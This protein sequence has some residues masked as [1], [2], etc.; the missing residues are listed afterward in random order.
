M[1]GKAS[2]GKDPD[3]NLPPPVVHTMHS[4]WVAANSSVTLESAG[5]LNYYYTYPKGKSDFIKTDIFKKITYKDIYPGIDLEYTFP[6]GKQGI[7]YAIILH[8]GADISKVKLE[9]SNAGGLKID[10]EGNV[11]FNSKVGEITDHAPVS[12]YS[13]GS[14][15]IDVSYKVSGNTE[16]F[17]INENYDKSK[18]LVI[19]PWSTDPLYSSIYDRAYDID[20]DY[21][22][23][24]YAFGSWMPL[25]LEKFSSTGSPLWVFNATAFDTY[26]YY[27]DVAV[28]RN[29]GTAYITEGFNSSGARAMKINTLGA[30]LGTSPGT[31]QLNEF[32]RAVF[33]PCYGNIIIGAGG[34]SGDNQACILDTNMISVTPVNILSATTPFHDI[35]LIAPDPS[36]LVCYMAT[37]QSASHPTVFNNVIVSLPLPSL[38]PT[39]YITPDNFGFQE[40]NV[41]SYVASG[42]D[43]ANGYDGIAVSPNWLYITNSLTL[44]RLYKNTG[45]LDDSIAVSSV[46]LSQNKPDW[47]GLAVSPCDDIF[48]G[49]QDTVRVY[50]SSMQVD[51][52]IKLANTI[53]DL[54]YGQNNL[55]YAAGD[56]FVCAINVPPLASLIS[57]ASG[58]PSSCSACDGRA[59]VTIN[60]GI[61]PFQFSWSNGSTNQTDTGMCAGIY[62]V[63]VT[64]GSC[65]PRFDSA[66][67]IITGKVGY[68]VT[69]RDTNPNCALSKGNITAYPTGGIPPY[70]YSW[71]NGETTQKDTGLIAGT[72]TCIVSDSEGCRTFITIT[73][74]NPVTPTI[75]VV[76]AVDS[77]CNGA[78]VP[79]TASGVKTYS[80]TPTS[81]LTCN[82]CPNP[83]A[84]PTVTTTYT[85]VGFDSNGCNAAATVTIK[86]YAVPKPVITGKDSVCSGYSDTL[87]ASGGNNYSWSTG[88][89]T[90]SIVK[91][92]SSTQTFTLTS[93]NGD[94]F[95][96]TT[97]TVHIVSPAAA[98]RPS[99]DSTC[100]GD[101]VKLTGS[102]GSTYLWSN[103]STTSVIIVSPTVPTTYTLY[104][105]YG[106]CRDSAT[107]KIGI[108]KPLTATIN[109]NVDSVCPNSPVVI[110][111]NITGGT[112]TYKWST[113]A[114]TSS[115]NVSDTVSTTYTATVYGKCDTLHLPYTVK[116]V[117]LPKPVIKGTAWKCLGKTDTLFASGGTTYL[118]SN[119]STGT[120]YIT[121]NI[122]AD[123]TITLI[124]FNSL[125]C[126]DTTTF[127]ITLRAA[128]KVTVNPPSLTCANQPV[129][130]TANA[131]G[132]GSLTYLWEPGGET[133]SS[134]TVTDSVSTTYT[135]TV[136]D[137]CTTFK[138]TTITPVSPPL[139]ACC[140]KVILQGNDT[141]IGAFGKTLASYTWAPPVTCLNP[142]WCD[143]VKVTPTVTTTYTVTGTDS[144][145]CQVERLVTIIV[146]VPC[147][148]FFVPNV[149]TP[150]N[151]G[152]LG[153]DN[154]FYIKTENMSAWSII[155]YDRW[156]KEMFNSTN[157]NSYWTGTTEGGGNAPDG[158]YY[159]IVTGTCQG[160]TYK[161]DGFL[162][163]IR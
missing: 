23:N 159:Y 148:N 14:G 87:V 138:T 50:N 134:I 127:T 86:V 126:A 99:K 17:S 101:T 19:D 9:Y 83:T 156:G 97:F 40:S 135:L 18:T 39:N 62:T 31:T 53:Y 24:V 151:K 96:D 163:L 154:V 130:L 11:V 52:T 6:N 2:S 1:K 131:T 34:T 115:I 161:R 104:A 59:T 45:A 84:T 65:P 64:D 71:S 38:A 111:A 133:S 124:A 114:T 110:S 122:D 117:P 33:N 93:N 92:I 98:I 26:G 29:S 3:E 118:W 146:D 144:V 123:S 16:S 44:K 152:S 68:G 95:H 143:T 47:G 145:G 35:V 72:Y 69:A 4:D 108:I 149:F 67:V 105:A 54:V 129:V 77:I 57:S 48:L 112:G 8:P 46:I 36:G 75:T 20:Y 103:H 147:F 120:K 55:L 128:P 21:N 116:V 142:P 61:S 13:S 94:C 136:S 25:Q 28:N 162:Q 12:Y 37:A 15:S 43:V 27:G 157:P 141:I 30:L 58:N 140:D 109:S 85:V 49:C 41:P 139:A 66:Q 70:T 121:K 137:G 88:A 22:G 89:T 150:N 73:L 7:E 155:I 56:S 91:V 74:K 106:S 100:A 125:G 10:K 32:W 132:T 79:L 113:G 107:V 90:T 153:L 80:W 42:N 63:R 119:G 102:G 81:G 158:V 60:C 82:T 5:K 78:S 51:T 76:P 160:N